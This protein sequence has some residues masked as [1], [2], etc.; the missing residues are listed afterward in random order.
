MRVQHAL[1]LLVLGLAGAHPVCAEVAFTLHDY[2][3]DPGTHTWEYNYSIN[4]A[5]GTA[6]V[7]DLWLGNLDGATVSA[8]WP[9]GWDTISQL[10]ATDGTGF[11]QWTA[12]DQ[13][14]WLAPG[15]GPLSGF[16]I[17][18]P[19]GPANT[20]AWELAIDVDGSAATIDD[21]IVVPGTVDG[22]SQ[23][24]QPEPGSLCLLGLA[25]GPALAWRRQRKLRAG[26][27]GAAE[28]A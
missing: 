2:S 19:Y 6:S 7:Y 23:F 8:S 24:S 27:A 26:K 1:L 16:T 9:H 4:N 18:S 22:P 13:A 14:D 28:K 11:A 5:A 15:A 12:A 3:Y 25:L 20:V 21:T 17:T 10:N